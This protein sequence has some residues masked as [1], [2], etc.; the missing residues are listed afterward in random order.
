LKEE[1]E[2]RRGKREEREEEREKR[3]KGSLTYCYIHRE[4]PP[5]ELD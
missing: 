2:K 3:E 5:G 1:R 4:L